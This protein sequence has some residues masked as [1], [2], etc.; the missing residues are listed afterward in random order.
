MWPRRQLARITIWAGSSQERVMLEWIRMFVYK[1]R[2]KKISLYNKLLQ[3]IR[4]EAMGFPLKECLL[5]ANLSLRPSNDKND[6]A[7]LHRPNE[8]RIVGDTAIIPTFK[9]TQLKWVSY[10]KFKYTILFIYIYELFYID[11]NRISPTPSI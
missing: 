11:S 4:E 7:I 2:T 10:N 8:K 3:M 9:W 5:P 6:R 1:R